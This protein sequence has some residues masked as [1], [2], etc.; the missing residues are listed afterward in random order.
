MNARARKRLEDGGWKI[1]TVTELLGLSPEDEKIIEM[2]LN[3]AEL[4]IAT[5]RKNNLTQAQV[6]ALLETSQSRIAF[7]E[8][9]KENVSF[10]LLIHGLLKMGVSPKAIGKSIERVGT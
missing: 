5:R 9:G 1:G 8:A 7:A 6:A 10:E 3:L 2:R 4:L